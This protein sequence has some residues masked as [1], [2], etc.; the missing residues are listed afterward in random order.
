MGGY[1][2]AGAALSFNNEVFMWFL[3]ATMLFMGHHVKIH[4]EKFP[5]QQDCMDRIE[6]VNDRI[7]KSDVIIVMTCETD[8]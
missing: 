2:V 8:A 3:V 7:E 1:C 5:T 4:V 6:Y